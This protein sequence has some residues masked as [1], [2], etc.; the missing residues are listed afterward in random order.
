MGQSNY[1]SKSKLG[2]YILAGNVETETSL[3]ISLSSTWSSGTIIGDL[4]PKPP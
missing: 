1:L 3:E 4:S 2:D